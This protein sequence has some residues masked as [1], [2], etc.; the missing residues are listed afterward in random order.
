MTVHAR[1]LCGIPDKSY[2]S[3]LSIDS[4]QTSFSILHAGLDGIT[5]ML[6]VLTAPKTT[7]PIWLLGML[8]LK[9]TVVNVST[10]LLTRL[11]YSPRD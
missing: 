7:D 9:A 11:L 4:R 8:T 10:G 5:I 6:R 3:I 1:A 2:R